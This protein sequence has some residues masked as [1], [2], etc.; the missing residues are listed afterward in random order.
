MKLGWEAPILSFGAR[1]ATVK[2][3]GEVR[4][5]SMTALAFYCAAIRECER[6]HMPFWGPSVER[7]C[8]QWRSRIASSENLKTLMCFSCA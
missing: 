5:G 4:N 7:R 6:E 1:V 2:L 3:H 8:L